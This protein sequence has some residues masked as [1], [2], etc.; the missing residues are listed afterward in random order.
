MTHLIYV[1][2]SKGL[3][4]S[5]QNVFRKG[6]STIDSI[7]LE[8]DIRKARVNKVVLVGVFLYVEKAIQYD[9]EGRIIN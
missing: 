3:L 5:H 1:L 7:C 9:V 6:H 8:N 4:N 2:E